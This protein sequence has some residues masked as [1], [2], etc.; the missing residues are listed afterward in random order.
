MGGSS[1]LLGEFGLL[2]SLTWRSIPEQSAGFRRDHQ[3]KTL[4]LESPEQGVF[5]HRNNGA[6]SMQIGPQNGK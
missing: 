4:T 5:L 6:A 1:T 2:I 3:K